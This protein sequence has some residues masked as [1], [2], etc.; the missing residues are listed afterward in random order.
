MLIRLHV[1]MHVIGIL[2]SASFGS[3]L[4]FGDLPVKS[5]VMFPGM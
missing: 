4:E 3:K 5:L 2:D 1:E